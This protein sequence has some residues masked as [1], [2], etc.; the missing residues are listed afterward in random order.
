MQLACDDILLD[1]CEEDP[2]RRG[3]A[4][5]ESRRPTLSLRGTRTASWMRSVWT[6]VSARAIPLYRRTSGGG[7][8]VQGPG[9]LNYS[10]HSAY[11]TRSGTRQH[12]IDQ[13]LRSGTYRSDIGKLTG[14]TVDASG[15]HGPCHR[16]AEVLGQCTTA[17]GKRGSLPRHV[18]PRRSIIDLIE[19]LLP[20]PTH[21]P[22]YREGRSHG[23]F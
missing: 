6:P 10:A 19:E 21:Q 23:D 3:P 17:E 5:L 11:G 14:A 16:R 20:M 18:P 1:L 7:T 8:V 12:L 22:E 9:C 4:R 13:R 15:S 2:G